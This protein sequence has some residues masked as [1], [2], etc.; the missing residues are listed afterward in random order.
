MAGVRGFTDTN[1]A[2]LVFEACHGLVLYAQSK[3][4]GPIPGTHKVVQNA[5]VEEMQT[6][7]VRPGPV[8]LGK[9]LAGRHRTR[10]RNSG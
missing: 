6:G 9:E 4:D 1:D 5:T 7:L 2:V 8:F 3:S 10:R